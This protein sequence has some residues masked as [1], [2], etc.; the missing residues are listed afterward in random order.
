M[1]ISTQWLSEYVN[2]RCDIQQLAEYLTMAGLEVEKVVPYRADFSGVVSARVDS[3]ETHAEADGLKV[4]QV[5]TKSKGKPVTVVCGADNVYV[6][7]MVALAPAG[8]ALP[9]N[10]IIKPVNFNH[11]ISAGILCSA[12]DLGLAEV[13][14]GLLELPDNPEIGEK[15]ED[16]LALD[17]HIIE[18]SL[19]PNRGDCL[20]I[21]GVARELCAINGKQFIAK[22]IVRQPTVRAKKCSKVRDIIIDELSVCPRYVGQIIEGVD[23]GSPC[24]LWLTE[25]LRRCGLHSVNTLVDISNYV[26]LELG[27]PLH[28]YDNDKLQGAV[29]VRYAKSGEKFLS[30]DN[31][32][33]SLSSETLVIAD[34]RHVI[35]AAGI[36]GGQDSAVSD[37]TDNIFLESAFFDPQ[38]IS[39][40]ARQYGL[41][42]D[43]SHRFER[44][45]D[46][47]LQKKAII[48][49]V[50]MIVDICGGRP[51]AIVDK[52]LKRFLPKRQKIKLRREQIE[53][54]LGIKQADKDI[55]KILSGLGMQLA[56]HQQGWMVQPPSFRFD[57][58]IEADLIEEISRIYGYNNIATQSLLACLHL[59][60]EN[61]LHAHQQKIQQCLISRGFQEVITY[62]FVDEEILKILHPEARALKLANPIAPE[63]SMMRPSLLPGLVNA[64]LYNQKRQQHR[65][66]LFETGL[67]FNDGDQLSQI[68]KVAGIMTGSAHSKQWGIDDRAIDFFDLKKDVEALLNLN[69]QKNSFHFV[70]YH[71]S[72]LHPRQSAEI[73]YNNQ[74]VGY[75]GA[76]HPSVQ[77]VLGIIKETFVFEL[78]I[79]SFLDK[80]IIICKK[81]SRFPLVKRDISITVD[82]KVLVADVIDFIRKTD[83][84]I[85]YSLELFD[86]Y[87]HELIDLERK[88]LSFSLI[89]QKVSST[90]TDD[91]VELVLEGVLEGLNKEFGALLRQ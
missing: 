19:T 16:I 91:D 89:F 36:I 35:S 52:T 62:S 20:S 64:L 55:T 26:M 59:N 56:S 18:L 45:V 70:P 15:L 90:L 8:A 10:V 33:L 50:Q 79:N 54:V 77:S 42:T 63:L 32:H 27:Q 81:L 9:G 17:D 24:P 80:E 83:T 31:Q 44:G 2:I 6:G 13:S 1:N 47:D 12:A 78:K 39:G 88:S 34:D 30:L 22:E 72:A 73:I 41:R 7:M 28:C 74:S 11:V 76:L 87:R 58:N 29:R 85:L 68:D 71:Y 40:R 84:E 21:V 23:A 14:V 4:C 82:K 61:D 46:F 25:K 38:V 86:V 3:V 65:I 69:Q 60:K 66:R 5:A 75:I 48:R 67:V 51:Q 57:I 37:T 53:R 49:A 43:A